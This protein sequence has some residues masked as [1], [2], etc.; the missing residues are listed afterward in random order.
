MN[1]DLSK[2]DE[3]SRA[4][5]QKEIDEYE[6]EWNHMKEFVETAETDP[7][8]DK[9][10]VEETGKEADDEEDDIAEIVVIGASASGLGVA[11]ALLTAIDLPKDAV[12]IFEGSP[13]VGASF[14]A[15]PPSTRF[16]SPSFY[17][18]PFNQTDLN[19]LAPYGDN[20]VQAF[21]NTRGGSVMNAQH[22][23]GKEYADYLDN[24]ASSPL[25]G[26]ERESGAKN[27]KD[28]ISFNTWVNSIEPLEEESEK[29]NFKLTLSESSP[30]STLYARYVIYAGGEVRWSEERRMAGAK[31]QLEL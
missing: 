22:P 21:L 19:A 14:R 11:S 28:Y 23:T 27:L 9:M 6:K 25:P 12:R 17:S 26:P 15:W 3:E 1:A 13:A 16:I 30:F 18:N 20:G 31:R 4:N 29:G 8:G 24:F 2:M 5:Y 7:S 10:D